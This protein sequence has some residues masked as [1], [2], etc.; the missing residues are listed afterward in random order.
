MTDPKEDSSEEHHVQFK[1]EDVLRVSN[2]AH[3]EYPKDETLAPPTPHVHFKG[4]DVARVVGK[5]HKDYPKTNAPKQHKVHFK[6]E[7]VARKAGKEHRDF[8]K[9][10]R[11]AGESA[12]KSGK[13]KISKEDFL[14]HLKIMVGMTVL[15]F[16]GVY[17]SSGDPYDFDSVKKKSTLEV[18]KE[19][20][21]ENAKKH[22]EFVEPSLPQSR[23]SSED[24]VQECDLFLT[25]S[26][27]VESGLGIFSIV[28]FEEGNVVMAKGKTMT[29]AGQEIESS[30]MLLKHH[31][32]FSNVKATSNGIIATKTIEAGEELFINLNDMSE[33]YTEY[34]YSTLH[35]NDPLD[36]EYAK[37]DDITERIIY[38][39]PTKIYYPYEGR[40][41]YKNK[42]K[43][44]E[45]PIITPIMDPGI[46]LDIVHDTMGDVNPRLAKIIPNTATMGRSLLKENGSQFFISRQR[47]LSW[48]TKNGVCLSGVSSQSSCPAKQAMMVQEGR[49]YGAFV[50]RNVVKDEVIASVPLFAVASEDAESNCMNASWVEGVSLCPLGAFASIRKGGDCNEGDQECSSSS[51]N[52]E[53][54]WSDFN[55]SNK[56]KE[57]KSKEEL[58][59]YPM[60]GLTL[61]II[62][63]RNIGRNEELFL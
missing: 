9:T 4:E 8:P 12:L 40:K 13:V 34:Y 11:P 55:S 47:E 45:D 43:K 35:P 5:E 58:L 57:K 2:K 52:V 15:F 53:Y 48:I 56:S 20:A 44:Y 54:S 21:K 29:V 41:N 25:E 18:I 33:S 42:K 50:T 38:A 49:Q 28:K 27:I 39:I 36:S 24:R 51:V 30:A 63:K 6:G 37:A 14:M 61:D 60:T 22:T 23:F 31:P 1:E 19:L 17:Y 7:D 26:S 62:A 46:I 10:H 3:K 16:V 59:K 32:Y